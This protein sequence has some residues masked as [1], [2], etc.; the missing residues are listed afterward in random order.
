MQDRRAFVCA[1]AGS[2]PI[3]PF[4]VFAQQAA[5]VRRIGWLRR[6]SHES[7]NIQVHRPG[8]R[9]L[10]LALL[11]AMSLIGAALAATVEDANEAYRRGDYE[12]ALHLAEPHASGGDPGAQYRL[13]VIYERGRGVAQDYAE[14]E[15][16]YRKSAVQGFAQAQNN[17]GH[18]YE[19]GHGVPQ[20]YGEAMKWYRKSAEQGYGLAEVNVGNMYLHGRGVTKDD[21]EAVQWY[22]KG[23][24]RGNAAAQFNLGAMYEHGRGTAKD[25]A[26]AFRWYHQAAEQGFARAQTNLGVMYANGRGIDKN[27]GEAVQWYRKAAA[28]GDATAQTNLGVMYRDGRGVPPDRAVALQWFRKA[29]EQGDTRAQTILSSIERHAGDVSDLTPRENGVNAAAVGLIFGFLVVIYLPVTW[30]VL[31]NVPFRPVL[32]YTFSLTIVPVFVTLLIETIVLVY[33]FSPWVAALLTKYRDTAA[34]ES[35]VLAFVIPT[36]IVG[37]WLWYLLFRQLDRAFAREA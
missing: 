34:E 11:A 7:A 19:I 4:E 8:L 1:V 31:R 22:R 15:R 25:E 35:L 13:G 32:K 28:Q 20:D 17:L 16:W 24:E 5:G 37:T 2:L 10:S 33:R 3:V 9:E 29:A 14:A 18:L 27:D 36:P 30:I 21:A 26:E 23:A 6:T 12:T